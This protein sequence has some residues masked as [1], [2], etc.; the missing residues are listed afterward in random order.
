MPVNKKRSLTNKELQESISDRLAK[1]D[2]KEANLNEVRTYFS[3]AGKLL[4]S[5][6]RD[7]DAAEYSGRGYQEHT[8]TFLGL[9]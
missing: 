5:V 4:S 8:K 9:K 3:G 1:L 2:S 7:M 6:N